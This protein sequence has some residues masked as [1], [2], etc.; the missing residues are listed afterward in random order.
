VASAALVAQSTIDV[1]TSA[2]R[3]YRERSH[4][5]AIAG[6]EL[7]GRRPAVLADARPSR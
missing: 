2:Y 6:L 1:L 7:R 3:R 5:R 4:H